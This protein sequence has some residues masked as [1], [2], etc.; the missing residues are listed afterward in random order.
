VTH[1]R[2]TRHEGYANLIY[3]RRGI[4]NVFCRIKQWGALCQFKVRATVNLI[5]VFGLH[6][7]AC[8]LIR[9]GDLLNPA[10]E[11]A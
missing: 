4:K 9:L 7:L 11:A 6:G 2:T 3:A 5:A 8:N 1:S 10:M